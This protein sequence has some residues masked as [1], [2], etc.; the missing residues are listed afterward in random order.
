MLVVADQQAEAPPP[1]EQLRAIDV[2]QIA[3][4]VPAASIRHVQAAVQEA[5]HEQRTDQQKRRSSKNYG[6]FPSILWPMNWPIQASTKMA[7]DSA[8]GRRHRTEQAQH[9][10]VIASMPTANRRTV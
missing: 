2:F 6:F 7:I 10:Q 3:N 4:T 5:E 1:E 8:P 9:Q